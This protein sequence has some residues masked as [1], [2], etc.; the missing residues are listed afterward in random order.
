[1]NKG[2][3]AFTTTVQ[4]SIP[5]AT[6]AFLSST[7]EE[8]TT[9]A[10]STN[11]AT[12]TEQTKKKK[13]VRSERILSGVQPTGSLH[14]GNY[15]GAIRQWVDFQNKEPEKDEDGN[16][17]PVE[18]YFC[19]VDLHAITMPHEPAALRESSLSSAALY[20]AAGIDPAKSKVFIQSHVPAHSELAW[21][22]NCIT[23]MNWLERMIQFKEKAKKQG[24]SVG[25]GL[26]TY[27]SLMA[28]DIMLYQS[29]KVPVG[30][31]QRQH[32]E[33]TRDIVRRFNDMFCT[34]NQYKKRCKAAGIASRPVFVEPNPII[35]KEGARV[36]SLTDGSSKMSK[37][38]PN[39]NSR[40]NVLDPPKVIRDKIKRCKTDPFEGIEWDNPERPEATNLLNIYSAVQPTPRSKEDILEEVKDMNWGQFKPLLA[41]AVVQHLEPIQKR[42]EE[43]RNNEE[44]LNQ[45]LKDGANAANE[46]A[47]RTLYNTK[48]A[49]GFVTPQE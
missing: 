38:D 25:V 28:A 10:T 19:V 46:V 41:E 7:K 17:I 18:T 23:P 27:P 22:L 36:M 49:M 31:D 33:L 44:E 21:L 12:S 16:P 8:A 13:I 32:L 45:I 37:S 5:R 42:Y 20:I 15:L 2:S 30:E 1:M 48:I 6:A 35:M 43:V 11:T 29:T 9:T 34:G 47:G 26:F 3:L 14:L 39:D 40:I 24:E 4:R